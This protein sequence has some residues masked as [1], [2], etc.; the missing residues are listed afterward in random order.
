[1]LHISVASLQQSFPTQRTTDRHLIDDPI[2]P[3]L[4]TDNYH[5]DILLDALLSPLSR[6]LIR[7]TDWGSDWGSGLAVEHVNASVLDLTPPF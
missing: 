2:C 6:D 5:G 7:Y 3:M 1:M 4:G